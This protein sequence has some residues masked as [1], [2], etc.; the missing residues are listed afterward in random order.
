MTQVLALQDLAARL[1]DQMGE[2]GREAVQKI[3]QPVQLPSE[4]I[5]G[6]AFTVEGASF[7]EVMQLRELERGAST[8]SLQLRLR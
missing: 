6:L 4:F 7:E 8:E 1:G 5:A 3:G 2:L